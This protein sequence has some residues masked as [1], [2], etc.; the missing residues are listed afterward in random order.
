MLMENDRTQTT[1]TTTS[2]RMQ[3]MLFLV[4]IVAVFV[5]ASLLEPQSE[6][7]GTHRQI[8]LPSCVV[9]K[10]LGRPCPHCGLT[11]SFCWMVRGQWKS[12][13]NANPSGVALTFI[14]VYF[15]ILSLQVLWR[16]CWLERIR[17]GH[18]LRNVFAIWLV[19]SLLVWFFRLSG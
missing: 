15:G 13:W 8:G 4:G 3:L 9:Q 1:V 18:R 12:A 14:L 10:M 6:G 5:M 2:E 16:G 11:T 17:F 7:Y 19:L